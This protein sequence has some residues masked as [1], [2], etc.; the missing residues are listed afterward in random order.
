MRTALHAAAGW[1]NVKGIKRM[2]ELC[3]DPDHD[4]DQYDERGWTPLMHAA[5]CD[6]CDIIIELIKGGADVNKR[7]PGGWSAL[8]RASYFNQLDTAIA[9]LKA[10]ATVDPKDT[11][12]DGCMTHDFILRVVLIGTV[13]YSN[14]HSRSSSLPIDLIRMSVKFF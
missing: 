13:I 6:H 1:G 2:I 12:M 14:Q 8:N 5:H 11:K 4:I 7:A 9:L 3:R 10:G